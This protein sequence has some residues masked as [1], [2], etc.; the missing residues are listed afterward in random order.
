MQFHV[1]TLGGTDVINRNVHRSI[2]LTEEE[3]G[4]GSS[5]AG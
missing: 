2:K 1:Q 4:D 5:S 3:G